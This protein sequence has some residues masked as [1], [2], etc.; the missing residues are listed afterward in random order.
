MRELGI[1]LIGFV[2][3][4]VS[5]KSQ[6]TQQPVVVVKEDLRPA[7]LK[8]RPI[9]NT[10]YIGISGTSKNDNQFDYAKNTKSKALED[11]ASEIKV[12]VE[13]NSVLFQLE[14]ND[15]FRDSYESVIKSKTSQEIEGFELVDVW[16]TDTEYWAYYRLSKAQFKAQQLKKQSTAQNL[17]LD[18]FKKGKS[19]EE[20]EQVVTALSSYLGALNAL[21]D[22]LGDLNEV[23]YEGEV[24]YLGSELFNAVQVLM[25]KIRISSESSI[26]YKRG[27][28]RNMKIVATVTYNNSSLANIPLKAEF[29]SG[30]GELSHGVQSNDRGK[31]TFV[32]STVSSPSKSQEIVLGIDLDK[33]RKQYPLYG[34]MLAS[35][36]LPKKVISLTVSGPTVYFESTEKNLGKASGS[37]L[38]KDHLTKK[39]VNQGFTVSSS[40][41]DADLVCIINADTKK[42]TENS[43]V[44][45][46]YMTV[47]FFIK[48]KKTQKVIYTTKLIDVKGVQ[49]DY[50][51]AGEDAYKKSFKKID[52]KILPEMQEVVFE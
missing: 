33:I 24:I 47:S 13:S 31:A 4:F 2:I 12:K 6:Q 32:L 11:L 15:S 5:C 27:V 40:K 30:K 14:R 3:F 35:V 36:Q 29:T 49:L 16:E 22:Y 41:S 28:T 25:K 45:V 50:E 21:H 38:L 9:D 39:I 43:G 52:K 42:G 19:F 51:K 46:S 10:Y 7:W 44:F 34:A 20:Q 8:N 17:A 1:S 18:L 37:L 48:N 23:E 26:D